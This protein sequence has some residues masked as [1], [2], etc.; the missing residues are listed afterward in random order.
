MDESLPRSCGR[1]ADGWCCEEH[2]A[3]A[4]GHGGCTGPAMP[5]ENVSCPY[6]IDRRPVPTRSGL[7]W[8]E[9]RRPVAT[10]EGVSGG[11]LLE[12]PAC[13]HRWSA[14]EPGAKLH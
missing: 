6:R 2:P 8:P 5:C 3:E 7:V 1:C 11:L 12:C 14:S 9:C 13:G 4:W 10:V